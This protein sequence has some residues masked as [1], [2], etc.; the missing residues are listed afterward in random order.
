MND[1]FLRDQGILTLEAVQKFYDLILEEPSRAIMKEEKL[2]DFC[3]SKK[4]GIQPVVTLMMKNS[5]EN[6]E[7][8][9]AVTLKNPLLDQNML[10]V[11]LADSRSKMGEITIPLPL[12]ELTKFKT[13]EPFDIFDTKTEEE[14]SLGD[15]MCYYIVFN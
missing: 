14:W 8:Y 2:K 1:G 5:E 4:D 9:H 10:T 15:E 3:Q 13:G 6:D 11:T 12:S 7:Y